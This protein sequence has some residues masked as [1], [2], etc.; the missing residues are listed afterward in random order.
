MSLRTSVSAIGLL[1]NLL[2][3]AG[4]AARSVPPGEA[5]AQGDAN[6][7]ADARG[8]ANAHGEGVEMALEV[9]NHNWSDIVVYLMRGSQSH[10][11]GMVTAASTAHFVFPYRH[12]GT[13]GNAR[14]QAHAVGGPQAVTSEN[15]LVQPGQGIKWTLESDLRQSFVAVQ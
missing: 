7:E 3:A 13:G 5:D 8:E 15:L 10:R 12:L 11:L 2:L 9:E 1:T 14:L 6:G 4:C